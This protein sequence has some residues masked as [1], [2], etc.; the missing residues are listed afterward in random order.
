MTY[1]LLLLALTTSALA[2]VITIGEGVE[3][4]GKKYF[5]Q[6]PDC[7]NAYYAGDN[8]TVESINLRLDW[9]VKYEQSKV[10]KT[11]AIM[12][13][14]LIKDSTSITQTDLSKQI[15]VLKQGEASSNRKL[16][17]KCTT[18]PEIKLL[19]SEKMEVEMLKDE[20]G[21]VKLATTPGQMFMTIDLNPLILEHDEFLRKLL[22]H[23]SSKIQLKLSALQEIASCKM[24]SS[25]EYMARFQD[26]IYYDRICKNTKVCKKY[27]FVTE[28]W[29]EYKCKH[30]P[31]KK[32]ELL[33]TLVTD[34]TSLELTTRPGTEENT[35]EYLLDQCLDGFIVSNFMASKVDRYAE[36]SQIRMD[37]LLKEYKEQY[38]F[39]TSVIEAYPNKL[40]LAL[41]MNSNA[42]AQIEKVYTLDR[43]DCFKNEDNIW[44]PENHYCI[45][46]ISK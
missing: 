22:N 9:K 38:S 44:L 21:L 16:Y 23:D 26:V 46:E 35:R 39:Q 36:G 29:E 12:G 8:F 17:D 30:I 43:F 45:K 34:K 19:S 18:V 3:K 5:L 15:A 7:K 10:Y 25:Y 11:P 2:N 33:D 31:H 32:R 6:F 28:C 20:Y 14:A 37:T 41:K 4:D 1:L 27:W 24:Q 13:F 40:N 42:R